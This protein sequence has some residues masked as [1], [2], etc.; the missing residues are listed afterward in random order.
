MIDLFKNVKHN[1]NSSE[2]QKNS[3]MLVKH[4]LDDKETDDAKKARKK[5]EKFTEEKVKIVKEK[6]EIEKEIKRNKTKIAE[7]RNAETH[8]SGAQTELARINASLTTE[9]P[10]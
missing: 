4:F 6:E 5:L 7:L 10:K 3:K 8:I 1:K 2:W 9:Q